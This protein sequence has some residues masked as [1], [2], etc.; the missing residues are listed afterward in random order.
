MKNDF[1]CKYEE[2]IIECFDTLKF[3]LKKINVLKISKKVIGDIL[4]KYYGKKIPLSNISSISNKTSYSLVIK[5]YDK[6]ILSEVRKTILKNLNNFTIKSSS[7]KFSIIVSLPEFT[8]NRFKSFIKIIKKQHELYKITL[9]EIRRKAIRSVNILL[10]EKNISKD[11]KYNY[12]NNLN[13][14]YKLWMEKTDNFIKNEIIL[15]KN[16]VF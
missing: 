12:L 13:K 1:I 10:K 7:D 5:V 14:I 6:S 9:R 2:N 8:E 11:E 15:I 16:N 3:N 4:I